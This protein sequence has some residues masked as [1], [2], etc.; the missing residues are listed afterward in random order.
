[1]PM[2][3][4]PA[5]RSAPVAGDITTDLPCARCGYNLRTLTA[6]ALCPECATP[7]VRSL[8]GQ[9][10]QFAD[11]RWLSTLRIG[12]ALLL[13]HVVVRITA[14]VLTATT[15][16]GSQWLGY[17]IWLAGDVLGV[18]AVF[19]LTTTEPAS[20]ADQGSATL[21]R[22]LRVACVIGLFSRYAWVLPGLSNAAPVA[23]GG[24]ISAAA[25]LF[26]AVGL[27]RYLRRLA[28]RIPDAALVSNTFVVMIGLGLI[29]VWG[30][31]LHGVILLLGPGGFA[32]LVG[33]RPFT[34]SASLFGCG[35]FIFGIL[36][37][38]VLFQYVNA[39]RHAAG[40]ASQM[41]DEPE[42]ESDPM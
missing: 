3:D 4:P 2:S 5:A 29:M 34:A 35:G 41:Q 39:F 10:L 26:L 42:L 23:A 30:V 37:V 27:L 24:V 13:G 7:V 18:V 16:F 9:L 12:T 40:Q 32:G 19:L 33:S 28:Q 22:V 17:L 25:N 1:M 38:V 11:P 31:F 8:Q 15:M 36:F 21:R 6:D 20:Q 14:S